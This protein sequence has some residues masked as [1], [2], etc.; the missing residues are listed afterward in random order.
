MRTH[1][2]RATAV[3][4]A[5]LAATSSTRAQSNWTGQ[6]S[7]NWFLSGN[8]LGGFPRQTDDANIN[9]VTPNSTA[10]SDSGA[11]ARNLAFGQNGIGMLT[12]QTGGTLADLSGRSAISRAGWVR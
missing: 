11:L 10:V 2:L 9:T 4:A 8:W 12:I 3:A 7:S 5:L 6:F 1:L